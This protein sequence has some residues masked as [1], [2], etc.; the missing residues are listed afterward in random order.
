MSEWR[1]VSWLNP[2]II[3]SHQIKKVSVVRISDKARYESPGTRLFKLTHSFHEM[4]YSHSRSLRSIDGH[5]GV[6][7][8]IHIEKHA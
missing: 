4:V 3:M 2:L 6:F 8:S 5:V 1:E 7:E